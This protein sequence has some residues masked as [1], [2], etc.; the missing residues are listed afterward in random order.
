MIAR[1]RP[2]VAP[3]FLA[4]CL[5]LGGSGQGVWGNAVLRLIAI[6]IIAWALLEKRNDPLPPAIRQLLVLIGLAVVL[7]LIQ[8]IPIPTPIWASLPG[9]AQF[10]EGFQILGT[11]PAAMT[12]PGGPTP[13]VSGPTKASGAQS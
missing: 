6:M 11:E 8:L 1:L 13:L 5:L 10:L 4:L 7:G 3:A 2:M 12:L 9:R